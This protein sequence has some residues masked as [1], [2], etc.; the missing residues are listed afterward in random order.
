MDTTLALSYYFVLKHGGLPFVIII[1][2]NFSFFL[3]KTCL[4]RF[5]RRLVNGRQSYNSLPILRGHLEGCR[6]PNGHYLRGIGPGAVYLVP[7]NLN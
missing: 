4:K 1:E 2:E 5:G 7:C 6:E 3:C